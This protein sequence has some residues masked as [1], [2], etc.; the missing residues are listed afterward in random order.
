MDSSFVRRRY[1]LDK[2]RICI[3]DGLS[4]IFEQGGKL[5]HSLTSCLT[6]NQLETRPNRHSIFV[7]IILI[8]VGLALARFRSQVSVAPNRMGRID[9]HDRHR[10]AWRIAQAYTPTPDKPMRSDITIVLHRQRGPVRE[11]S[12]PPGAMK[13]PTIR[14]T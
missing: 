1:F 8:S 12:K 3:F 10:T 5:L 4:G 13:V 6:E 7:H 14:M 2:S 9:L 11:F